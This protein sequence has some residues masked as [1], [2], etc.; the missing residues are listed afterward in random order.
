MY[1]TQMKKYLFK[2]F[3]LLV[4]VISCKVAYQPPVTKAPSNYLVVEGTVN[5]NNGSTDSTFF[6]LSRTVTIGSVTSN[7]ELHAQVIIE[8]GQNYSFTLKDLGKGIYAAGAL[9]IDNTKKYRVRIKTSDGKVYLSDLESVGYT[10]PIDSI[11]LTLLNNGIQI[12]VNT[13]NP[14]DNTRYYRWEFTE[15]WK[16]R[17]AYNSQLISNGARIVTR[18]PDQQVNVCW[19]HD[20]STGIIL[21]SSAKLTHDVIYQAPITPIA[22]TSEK[23]E[24]RY[25]ILLKQYALTAGAFAFWDQLRK[26]TENLG[27]IFDAQPSQISGNIHCVTNPAEQVFGYI[28]VTDVQSKR[29]YINKNTSNIPASFQPDAWTKCVLPDTVLDQQPP[30]GHAYLITAKDLLPIGSAYIPVLEAMFKIVGPF[31][32]TNTFNTHGYLAEPAFCVDCTT[33]GVTKKPSFWVDQ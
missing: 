1:I 24:E 26:N 3:T 16:F 29:V 10:P 11:G 8:D 28:S 32:P 17:T 6:K 20:A 4:L 9:G 33:R 7:P 22:A 5:S 23:I 12:Y 18:T 31:P 15:D 21:G 30:S 27:S 2:T 14:N 19:G 13:H 25:S